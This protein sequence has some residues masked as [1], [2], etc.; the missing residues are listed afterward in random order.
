MLR[1]GDHSPPY[2]KVENETLPNIYGWRQ[3]KQSQK[4]KKSVETEAILA[5]TK[6]NQQ[7]YLYKVQVWD[8][9]LHLKIIL[10]KGAELPLFISELLSEDAFLATQ[11]AGTDGL[12]W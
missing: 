4:A 6:A 10:T 9:C 5:K 3:A 1:G 11:A 2:R 8:V 7:K 12:T